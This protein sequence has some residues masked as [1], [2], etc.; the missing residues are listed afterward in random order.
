MY[1]EKTYIYLGTYLTGKKNPRL[2]RS[3]TG[4]STRGLTMASSAGKERLQATVG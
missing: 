2:A 4:P 1:I 3:R